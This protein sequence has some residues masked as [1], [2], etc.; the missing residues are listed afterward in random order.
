MPECFF[1]AHCA[2]RQI[3]FP[4]PLLV[5]LLL[6]LL[7]RFCHLRTSS[8]SLKFTQHFVIQMCAHQ[9]RAAPTALIACQWPAVS[10]HFRRRR[11]G[12]WAHIEGSMSAGGVDGQ[13]GRPAGVRSL[14]WAKG[15]R[16]K[17]CRKS[18][19]R[20]RQTSESG[21]KMLRATR[22]RCPLKFIAS[23][24]VFFFPPSILISEAHH[25]TELRCGRAE[26]HALPSKNQRK[27]RCA[28]E[29]KEKKPEAEASR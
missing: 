2:R 1:A 4:N 10:L 15:R 20:A 11:A 18:H 19:W 21:R 5:L 22:A 25:L 24:L 26:W 3:Y 29:A 9:S 8:E 12:K 28:R 6:L 16:A 14:N 23:N 17:I 7:S 13:A 27:P